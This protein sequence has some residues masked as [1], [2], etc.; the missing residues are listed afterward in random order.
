MLLD[1]LLMKSG[2]L[3]P[4]LTESSLL[5]LHPTSLEALTVLPVSWCP[6]RISQLL[7]AV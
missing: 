5:I 6:D 4:V 2:E 7:Q 1:L 3:L